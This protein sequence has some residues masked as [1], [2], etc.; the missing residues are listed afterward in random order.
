MKQELQLLCSCDYWHA[1]RSTKRFKVAV[2]PFWCEMPPLVEARTKDEARLAAHL[3]NSLVL[4]SVRARAVSRRMAFT[5][6]QFWRLSNH[7]LI[8]AA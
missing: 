8:L 6:V 3:V 1:A 7:L 4:E 2:W 5:H